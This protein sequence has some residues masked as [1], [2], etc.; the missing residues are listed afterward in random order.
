MNLASSVRANGT[1]RCARLFVLAGETELH[2]QS[3]ESRQFVWKQAVCLRLTQAAAVEVNASLHI[4]RVSCDLTSGPKAGTLIIIT[5]CFD[6]ATLK[7]KKKNTHKGFHT[8]PS[9]WCFLQ[10]VRVNT[11][12]VFVCQFFH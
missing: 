7:R 8:Y 2:M 12:N 1:R 4:D 5:S 10:P 9:V 3:L 11:Q 6:S